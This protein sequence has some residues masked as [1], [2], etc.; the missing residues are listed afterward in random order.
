[1]WVRTRAA[2]WASIFRPYGTLVGG[3]GGGG[4]VPAM[5]RG[6]IF[7]S[8]LRHGVS[9]GGAWACPGRRSFRAYR[10]AGRPGRGKRS[11][12]APRPRRK[13]LPARIESQQALA[14]ESR[15]VAEGLVSQWASEGDARGGVLTVLGNRTAEPRL[16]RSAIVQRPALADFTLKGVIKRKHP[17]PSVIMTE[18]TAE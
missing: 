13:G 7:V 4:R 8:C 5:N 1:M 18:S 10:G 6:A 3:G 12:L 15:E 16:A 14:R 11:N 9:W 17:G 2:P